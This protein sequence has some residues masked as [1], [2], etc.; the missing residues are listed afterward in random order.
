[1]GGGND[2][3]AGAVLGAD[4]LVYGL[5]C[6]AD[7]VVVID[8][9]TEAVSTLEPSVGASTGKWC[10]GLLGEDGFVYCVPMDDSDVLVIDTRP[11]KRAAAAGRKRPLEKPK[12]E[13]KGE[14][15]GEQKGKGKGTGK[16]GGKSREKGFWAAGAA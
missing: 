1:L 2:K 8:P 10:D 12:G 3:Y 13:A 11:G 9:E 5:P 4:G 16:G 6:N 7:S 14:A 15:K